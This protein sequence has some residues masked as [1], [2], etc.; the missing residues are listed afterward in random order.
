MIKGS[1]YQKALK[2]S[3]WMHITKHQ[4]TVGKNTKIEKRDAFTIIFRNINIPL[5]VDNQFSIDLHN[6]NINKLVLTDIYRIFNN[7]RIHVFL[8][9][10]LIF[11]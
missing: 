2:S 10:T 1:V 7:S 3:T 9:L 6:L 8:K 4:N 11:T 5:S